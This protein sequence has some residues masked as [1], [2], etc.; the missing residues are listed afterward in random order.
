M[1]SSKL[2]ILVFATLA[3]FAVAKPTDLDESNKL[4]ARGQCP[5]GELM[6]CSYLANIPSLIYH[7]HVFSCRPQNERQRCL[8][9]AG[10]RE[11]GRS[12]GP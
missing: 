8:Q 4:G 9:E 5:V 11:A 6:C 2:S 7:S 1:I 12:C 10:Y 3:A